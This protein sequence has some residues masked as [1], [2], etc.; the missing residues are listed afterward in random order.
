MRIFIIC[1]TSR[2]ESC[3]LLHHLLTYRLM[4]QKTCFLIFMAEESSVLKM[5]MQV[6]LMIW[7][8]PNYMLS[9]PRR[10]NI[11]STTVTTSNP[12]Y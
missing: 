9:P 11:I 4:F 5:D 6:H 3:G 1:T 2:L 7:Y 10:L 8:L 12:E